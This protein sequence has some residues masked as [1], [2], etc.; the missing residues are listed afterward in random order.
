VIAASGDL[1][2]KLAT[3][4]AQMETERQWAL[5]QECARELTKVDPQEGRRVLDRAVREAENEAALRRFSD[6]LAEADLAKA[7]RLLLMIPQ[8]SVYRV[9]AEVA[10]K[11]VETACDF[12]GNVA[13]GDKAVAVSN[14]SAALASFELALVCKSDFPVIRK[15]YV[16]ACKAKNFVAAKKHFMALGKPDN[17]AQ[18]CLREGYDPRAAAGSGSGAS[19]LAAADPAPAPTGDYSSLV[20]RADKAAE[21]NCAKARELYLKALELKPNGADALTGLGYC[22][23][24]A[25]N[26]RSAHN[27]FRAALGVSPR[28]EPALWGVAEAYQQQGMKDQAIE[29]YR[30]YLEVYRGS[31]KA[32]KQIE[33][34]GGTP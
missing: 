1:R 7:R 18:T 19:G 25:K 31:A 34:L 27:R 6:A 2:N 14:Y 4:C 23:L 28:Y 9:E 20:A 13:M 16:A 29:A 8:D 33:R 12:D 30:K 17:L 22:D 24:D 26:F 15:A 21:V 10:L 11:R 3:E 5:A 32:T